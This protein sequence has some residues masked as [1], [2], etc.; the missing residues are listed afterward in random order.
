MHRRSPDCLD[1]SAS[2]GMSRKGQ[3][4]KSSY[5]R[6]G[7]VSGK[8][9]RGYLEASS[10]CAAAKVHLIALRVADGASR[11]GLSAGTAVEDR[12]HVLGSCGYILTQLPNLPAPELRVCPSQP[13]SLGGGSS[14][15]KDLV[16]PSRRRSFELSWFSLPTKEPASS[17]HWTRGG[18]RG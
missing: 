16:P 6:K 18:R 12:R 2:R 3:A 1:C 11:C 17:V 13:G 7:G 14:E 10:P 9:I 15:I 4:R 5:M 8:A